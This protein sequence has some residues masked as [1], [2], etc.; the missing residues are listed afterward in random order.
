MKDANTIG[1]DKYFHAKGNYEAAN[2]GAGGK[3]AAT[4]IRYC[5]YNC[6]VENEP[7]RSTSYKTAC[8]PGEDSD[9]LV[10]LHRL[11]SLRC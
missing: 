9:H 5:N 11:I 4:L 10:P 8:L 3:H 1:A 6:L 2:R 7:R